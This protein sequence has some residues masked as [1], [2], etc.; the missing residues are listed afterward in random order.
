MVID[1]GVASVMSA[2]NMVNGEWCGESHPL[3]TDGFAGLRCT[4]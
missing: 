3:L 1:E 4:A 2:Y